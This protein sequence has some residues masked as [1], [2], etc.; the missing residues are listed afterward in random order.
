VANDP[1][2]G[3]LTYIRIYSGV[4]A[5][6]DQLYNPRTEKKERVQKLVKMHANSREEVGTI[7]AGDIGAVVG[8]KFTSTGDT[9]CSVLQPVVLESISFPEPVI[10]I[11]IE[12][13]ST[14][15]QEK[16][17]VGLNKLEKEDPSCRV[18]FDQ[19]SGQTLL[20]GMGELHLEILIDRLF[21]EYK[22][23]AN[24]GKPQVSY[25][26]TITIEA[27]GF[28]VYDRLVANEQQFAKVVLHI[29]PIDQNKGIE[30]VSEVSLSKE[31]TPIFLKAIES[32]FREAAEVGPLGNFGMLGVRGILKEVE[33]KPESASEMAF[34]AASSLALR[35]AVNKANPELLEPIFKIEIFCPDD[36][37]GN[38]VSDLNA[39]RGKIISMNM[40]MS[41]NGQVIHAEVPL[42]NL[43][44]YATDIRSLSQGRATFNM[45][46]LRYSSVPSKAK[47]EIMKNMGR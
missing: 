47:L 28:H 30:F 32:G 44:G 23:Q 26:E 21:R 22:I 42:A 27:D 34:K 1:F 16:M 13:K 7:K 29:K 38:I 36:F 11:A 18:R 31:F 3:T 41:G 20:S 35:E 37:V 17:L 14:A 25:R 46:F 8:L 4:I 15:D 24:V 45:E 9:L 12:A 39:R 6:G 19:E 40:K 2:A 43:F 10:S 5:V 33:V